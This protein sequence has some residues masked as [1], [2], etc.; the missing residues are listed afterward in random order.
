MDPR[1]DEVHTNKAKKID[2]YKPHKPHN[3]F[4]SSPFLSLSPQ[5]VQVLRFK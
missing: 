4:P 2:A 5:K 3:P 1:Y